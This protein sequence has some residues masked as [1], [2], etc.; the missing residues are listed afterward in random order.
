MAPAPGRMRS[1]KR[2]SSQSSNKKLL[3]PAPHGLHQRDGD[4]NDRKCF[5]RCRCSVKLYV[6]GHFLIKHFKLRQVTRDDC[7]VS[8]S[9]LSN[10]DTLKKLHFVALMM[11][12]WKCKAMMAKLLFLNSPDSPFFKLLW[13]TFVLRSQKNTTIWGGV[14][15]ITWILWQTRMNHKKLNNL[16]NKWSNCY[17]PTVAGELSGSKR[18]TLE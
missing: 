6:I 16:Q 2:E 11:H 14:Q 13:P 15:R 12:I 5:K 4:H 17:E 1:K 10:N 8:S 7:W 9:R 18:I 3:E